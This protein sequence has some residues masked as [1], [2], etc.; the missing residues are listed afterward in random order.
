MAHRVTEEVGFGVMNSTIAGLHSFELHFYNI[1]LE[2]RNYV[3]STESIDI[4]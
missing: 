1:L 3:I 4:L 2:F